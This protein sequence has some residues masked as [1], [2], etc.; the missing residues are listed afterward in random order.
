M[1]KRD[2]VLLN[3]CEN[4]ESLRNLGKKIRGNIKFELIFLFHTYLGCQPSSGY[5]GIMRGIITSRIFGSRYF[6]VFLLRGGAMNHMTK[7]S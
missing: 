6:L 1:Q 2:Q 4:G 3:E 7:S 5:L